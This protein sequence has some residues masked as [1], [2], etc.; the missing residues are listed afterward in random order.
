MKKHIPGGSILQIIMSLRSSLPLHSGLVSLLGGTTHCSPSFGR[1]SRIAFPKG[2]YGTSNSNSKLSCSASLL[3]TLPK[4]RTK[5]PSGY[6]DVTSHL[7]MV[8]RIFWPIREGAWRVRRR[9]RG[10][11]RDTGVAKTV[12]WEREV[13]LE[14]VNEVLSMWHT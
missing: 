8:T 7:S 3:S 6:R 5:C 11:R 4:A 1:Q 12:C 14:D 10:R 13:A 2:L 9:M